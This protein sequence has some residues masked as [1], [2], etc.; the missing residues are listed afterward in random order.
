M[1]GYP[2][3]FHTPAADQLHIWFFHR[4]MSFWWEVSFYL[5]Q[6]STASKL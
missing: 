6:K 4:L 3:I 2:G 5:F 1:R